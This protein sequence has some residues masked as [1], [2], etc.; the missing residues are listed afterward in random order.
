MPTFCRAHVIGDTI[1]GLLDGEWSDFE[2]IVQDDG[3]GTDGT[4]EAVVA[5]ARGDRRVV[6]NRNA[7]KLGIPGNLNAAIMATR[8]ELI[9]MCHDHDVYK[10]SFLRKM[11]EAL[12]RYPSAL[13]VHCAIDTITQ[14]GQYVGSFINDFAEL[15]PGHEWLKVM[16]STLSCQVCAL[17][18]VRR[19]AHERYGLYNPRFDFVSDVELWM[20]LSARGD[21]AYVAAPLI[22]V[23]EREAVHYATDNALKLIRLTAAIHREYLGFA[24]NSSEALIR[25]LGLEVTAAASATHLRASRARHHIR[26]VLSWK[27]QR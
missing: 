18:V 25:R 19:S 4:H 26:R 24:Y 2:L 6:Y 5:A 22:Q 12:E 8:G 7:H 21:V 15:T 11:V 3:D 9:A 20:R 17:T 10:P 16:L 27:P 23:R 13:F 1:R 14:S